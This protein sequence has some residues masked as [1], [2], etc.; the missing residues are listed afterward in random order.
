M[1]LSLKLSGSPWN[2]AVYNSGKSTIHARL[3]V[4]EITRV[5]SS[6]R[7]RLAINVNFGGAADSFFFQWCPGQ[8]SLERTTYCALI[9]S[10]YDR[11]RMLQV[12]PPLLPV[13]RRCAEQCWHRGALKQREYHG[14]SELKLG[15]CPWWSD[16]N[17][18]VESRYFVSCLLGALMAAGWRV[19]A[20]A[21]L[22]RHNNDKSTF[23]LRQSAPRQVAHMCLA[24][25]KTNRLR[26]IVSSS[27]ISE[28]AELRLTAR[29]NETIKRHW[30]ALGPRNYGKSIEWKLEGD[31]WDMEGL[32]SDQTRG[33]YLLCLLLDVI[34]PLGWR[35]VSSA[36][37]ASKNLDGNERGYA[38]VGRPEDLH[39]WFFLFD[40]TLVHEDNEEVYQQHQYQ[41][42]STSA[43]DITHKGYMIGEDEMSP[44][45][46][47]PQ[48]Q[49]QQPP[50]FPGYGRYGAGYSGPQCFPP[51]QQP[52]FSGGGR[53]L[54]Y[55]SLSR[56]VPSVAAATSASTTDPRVMRFPPREPM[57]YGSPS[58]GQ[59]QQQYLSNSREMLHQGQ[60][61]MSLAESGRRGS[62]V[63]LRQYQQPY[64]Q[65]DPYNRHQKPCMGSGRCQSRQRSH[66]MRQASAG[67]LPPEPYFD[68][69]FG[70]QHQL[71]LPVPQRQPEYHQS[72]EPHQQQSGE[73]GQEYHSYTRMTDHD[74]GY[75]SD[76]EGYRSDGAYQKDNRRALGGAPQR[77]RK[78]GSHPRGGGGGRQN[79]S[80]N[81][82]VSDGEGYLMHN[83]ELENGRGNKRISKSGKY[84]SQS[85]SL[86]QETEVKEILRNKDSDDD[87][88]DDGD[89]EELD[90]ELLR[91]PS[92]SPS[93]LPLPRPESQTPESC[94]E[95]NLIVSYSRFQ[96][97]VSTTTV[98]AAPPPT[99]ITSEANEGSVGG[100][101]SSCEELY[102][103]EVG[104]EVVLDNPG[105]ADQQQKQVRKK[106]GMVMSGVK[107]KIRQAVA[108][109]K[110]REALM[111]VDNRLQSSTSGERSD[112]QLGPSGRAGRSASGDS[113]RE[114][115]GG[116]ARRP[117]G[118]RSEGSNESPMHVEAL[119]RHDQQEEERRLQMSSIDLIE[120]A[121][122]VEG[123]TSDGIRRGAGPKKGGSAGQLHQ[124][125]KSNRRDQH[126]RGVSSDR[127]GGVSNLMVG[128]AGVTCTNSKSLN[129]FE[130]QESSG[131][132]HSGQSS[133]HS[134]PAMQQQHIQQQQQRVRKNRQQQPLPLPPVHQQSQQPMASQQPQFTPHNHV[135]QNYP[136]VHQQQPQPQPQFQHQR[137]CQLAPGQQIESC[138]TQSSSSSASAPPDYATC[139]I[140][141][142]GPPSYDQA[143]EAPP[144]Q[145]RRHHHHHHHHPPPPPPATVSTQ[146]QYNQGY[147]Q[148]QYH[149]H[150]NPPLVQPQQ[151]QQQQ[152]HQQQR[153]VFQR[154]HSLQQ[155]Q[156]QQQLQLQLQQHQGSSSRG[157]S[158]R[159]NQ[160]YYMGEFYG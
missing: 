33:V 156:Q 112:S 68:G 52:D 16:G 54:S 78:G 61:Q 25:A 100:A 84:G 126:Q 4:L 22:S 93:G 148:Q 160:L 149:R 127:G 120:V 69:Y 8:E 56:S 123:V 143:L 53:L 58:Q 31:P 19:C 136:V 64:Q 124:Y 47:H 119:V 122:Q 12:P 110:A 26:L 108:N 75:K 15:G 94:E 139:S 85:S 5:L 83:P 36:D 49:H 3:V 153:K 114:S 158:V 6:F 89:D 43:H 50:V 60:P 18:S 42:R 14:T 150:H 142:L 95:P 102:P 146:Q 130:R 55:Q 140:M 67:S 77:G 13:V 106:S 79:Y 129:S 92:E 71:G 111:G 154:Q 72:Y 23:I 90:E 45:V 74:G 128:N 17:D 24:L 2:Q 97:E 159:N 62:A 144:R 81:G 133:T 37:V 80:N 151:Q 46:K 35:L 107:Q 48:Q 125:G 20:T 138:S 29:I 116:S 155:Q 59:P 30:V 103:T 88:D 145:H 101:T 38:L 118:Y 76:G 157:E 141:Q 109:H 99:Q 105:L 132:F 131:S 96:A 10:R 104:G 70:Q 134:A 82:Y 87:D 1:V 137:H 39:T 32:Y 73:F 121:D 91:K 135:Y 98:T 147:D 65:S 41:Y 86:Y 21:D 27:D 9:L 117:D 51:P 7:W 28:E 115:G 11:L 34:V 40:E 44:P 113:L 152:Q 63:S 66:L 57:G